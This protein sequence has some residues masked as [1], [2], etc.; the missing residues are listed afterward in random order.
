MNGTE[1]RV[2][3][4]FLE[5]FEKS[6]INLGPE[7]QKNFILL[8]NKINSLSRKFIKGQQD[9]IF[10]PIDSAPIDIPVSKLYN[11]DSQLCSFILDSSTKYKSNQ[12]DMLRLNLSRYIG[13][14]ILRNSPFEDLRKKV[15]M[16]LNKENSSL[17]STLEDILFTRHKVANLVGFSSYSV[18]A[19]KD[20]MA[21]S[22]KN[23]ESFLSSL[24]K[25]ESLRWDAYTKQLLQIQKCLDA[26][27]FNSNTLSSDTLQLWNRDFLIYKNQ[28]SYSTSIDFRPYFSLGRVFMGIS[29]LLTNLYGVH[30]ESVEPSPGEI[31]DPSVKKLEVRTDS[32]LLL[33]II[34]CD[35]LERFGKSPIGAAHF[36]VKCSRRVDDD[37]FQNSYSYTNGPIMHT[38]NK[39]VHQLPVVV[40][41]CSFKKSTDNNLTLLNFD[42]VETLFHEMG[43]AI[44]SMLGG[45]DFQNISGTRCPMDFVELPSILMEKFAS[46]YPVLRMFAK[47]YITGSPID[48]GD[49]KK[50]IEAKNSTAIYDTHSQIFMSILDLRLHSNFNGE[51]DPASTGNPYSGFS[52]NTL[53]SLHSDPVFG[54]VS[55]NIF[56]YVHGTNWL[57]KFTHLIG[58]G[59]SYYAYLFDRVLAGIV[60]NS[61]FSKVLQ[62]IHQEKVDDNTIVDFKSA[63]SSPKS[64]YLGDDFRQAGEAY[65]NEILKWGGGRDPWVSLAKLL[66]HCEHEI[67]STNIETLSKG[68]EKA[69]DIVGSWG[70]SP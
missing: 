69:M 22:P 50:Y 9:S 1:R 63:N 42:E 21:K 64:T 54:S 14:H 10:E 28:Q 19:L 46:S 11:L 33:G 65:K 36:N 6:G 3:A 20:K 2:G 30:L 26:K 5:D 40:L 52:T 53:R 34:Y 16:S 47:N 27:G 25:Q 23:V 37:F 31:W 18:L 57:P 59:S 32:G 58:Y 35:L 12:G 48:K 55:G 13:Q 39:K 15:Y 61:L 70:L 67:G 49:F 68:N 66:S 17:Q 7:S 38:T 24:A 43:H 44:H 62:N 56:P 41:V 51:F 45:T 4:L 29:R 8:N 60:F